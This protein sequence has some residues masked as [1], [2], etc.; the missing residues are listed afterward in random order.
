MKVIYQICAAILGFSI[1]TP[2]HAA[3]DLPDVSEVMPSI[4]KIHAVMYRHDYKQPWQAG[5]STAGTGSGFLI[6]GGQLLTCGHVVADAIS[7]E[8]QP[9]GSAERYPARVRYIA[10]ESDLAILE[11]E[12][13]SVLE[14]LKELPLDDAVTELGDEVFAVGFPMGGTRLSLTRGIVSRI[15]HSVYSFSGVDSRLVIQIDAAINPGNSGGPVVNRDNQVVGVAF[16][17]IRQAQGLGYVIPVSVIQ[18]FLTDAK[19]PPYHGR[20]QL[21]LETF[22]LRNPAMRKELGLEPTGP[23]VII[24]KVSR[25]CASKDK[26]FPGDVLLAVD[27]ISIQQ[28]GTIIADGNMLPF[29]ELVE[30]K[31]WGDEVQFTLLRDGKETTVTFDLTPEQ[32]PFIFR[33]LYDRPPE[34][35]ITAGLC[36]SPL[37]R[38]FMM[39]LGNESNN[40]L[41]PILYFFQRAMFHPEI[42]KRQHI[43]ALTAILPHPVNTYAERYENQI[44]QSINETTIYSL[45]DVQS[46][47]EKPID[48][49]HVLQFEGM[50]TPLVLAADMLPQANQQIQQRY[51]IMK[52]YVIHTESTPDHLEAQ[53]SST[54]GES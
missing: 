25:Y 46:A 23:G 8:V 19:S 42:E 37:S 39:T 40:A 17:G 9:N 53:H 15:D 6:E 50:D 51:G 49:Y 34:Y 7:I 13:P 38:N 30:R 36:F 11:L 32:H 48:G 54:E 27:G 5:G 20:P 35:F 1:I 45:Q 24:T 18:H 47:L 28:D 52:P 14:G 3:S 29:Q 2:L 33:R 10:Y 43:I 4:F 12:D 31:Q 16:Q 22:D 44:I 26:L 41:I 21:Y